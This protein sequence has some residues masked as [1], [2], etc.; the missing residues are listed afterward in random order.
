MEGEKEK[1]E[2][3]KRIEEN[4]D[5][6]KK[7]EEA[8]KKWFSAERD[9]FIKQTSAME[10]DIFKEWFCDYVGR[11]SQ[12]LPSDS[13]YDYED[14]F[15]H[16]YFFFNADNFDKIGGELFFRVLG[17]FYWELEKTILAKRNNLIKWNAQKL[18]LEKYPRPESESDIVYWEMYLGYLEASIQTLKLLRTSVEVNIQNYGRLVK[19]NKKPNQET[20]K[21]RDK[22][23]ALT[24]ILDLYARG[25]QVPTN[26]GGFAATTLRKLGKEIIKK[27]SG[28][29]F[30][31]QVKE[32]IEN[33]DLNS[34]ADL[35]NISKNWQE[36]L[37]ELSSNKTLLIKYLKNKGLIE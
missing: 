24:Y 35:N 29:G 13:T 12:R 15:K 2:I 14:L 4:Q 19:K 33:Y 37:F 30:Y 17:E 9:H 10:L 26:D 16:Y 3:V 6:F 34:K 28:E 36:V 27:N 20:E 1:S 8:Q 7:E 32:I 18:I 11:L 5:Y 23:Y 22:H 25:E 31:R 21:I